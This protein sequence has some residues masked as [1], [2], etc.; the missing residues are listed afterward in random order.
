MLM[1]LKSITGKMEVL[2]LTEVGKIEGG[3]GQ[4]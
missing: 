1:F 4:R 2:L 3:I